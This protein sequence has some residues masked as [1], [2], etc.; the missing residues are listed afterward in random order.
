MDNGY[1]I[2]KTENN[3]YFLDRTDEELQERINSVGGA[4]YGV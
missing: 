1:T 3:G 4:I 2:E